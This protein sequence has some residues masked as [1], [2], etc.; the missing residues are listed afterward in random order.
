MKFKQILQKI[1]QYFPKAIRLLG[2]FGGLSLV[3]FLWVYFMGGEQIYFSFYS[4]ICLVFLVLYYH[5][6]IRLKVTYNDDLYARFLEEL[7]EES[8]KREYLAFLFKQKN[9][10]CN[11]SLRLLCSAYYPCG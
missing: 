10:G 3:P 8:T 9:F 7:H 6:F 4:L 2:M 1:S 11:S 5:S